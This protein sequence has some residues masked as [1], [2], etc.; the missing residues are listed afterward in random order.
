MLP[1]TSKRIGGDWPP[2]LEELRGEPVMMLLGGI[3]W[4]ARRDAEQS[5]A[6]RRFLASVERNL[7][8]VE[9]AGYAVLMAMGVRMASRKGRASG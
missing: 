3:V 6:A 5:P 8:E 4:R 1:E 7:G 9:D 2:E